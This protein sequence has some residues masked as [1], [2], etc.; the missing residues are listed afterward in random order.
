[1]KSAMVMTVLLVM[2]VLHGCTGLY[3]RLPGERDVADYAALI[4]RADAM[5]WKMQRVTVTP[6]GGR[7]LSIAV[8]DNE[9][10]SA[11]ETVVL[12]HG[13]TADNWSWRYM[14]GALTDYRIIA[15]D[16]PGCG[17][18]DAPQ[19]SDMGPEGYSPTGLARCS[20]EAL[21]VHLRTHPV[22]R[23]TLTAH[24]YG[25]A[26]VL[27]MFGDD[28]L[29]G[30]YQD[31]LGRVKLLALFAPV[32]M[33]IHEMPASVQ[34]A[35]DVQDWQVGLAHLLGMM[36]DLSADIIRNGMEYERCALR[37]IADQEAHMLTDAAQRHAL[38][39]MI[40]SVIP[41][42]NGKTIDWLAAEAWVRGYR[43]VQVPCMIVWGNHDDVLDRAGG[44]E[45]QHEIPQVKL[46]II[47]NARHSITLEQPVLCAQ[48]LRDFVEDR[49]GPEDV[50]SVT[51]RIPELV[52][53][54]GRQAPRP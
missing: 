43:Q 3:A 34:R 23:F 21:R 36:P 25:G 26:V 11:K 22:E 14:R 24:S 10:M 38:Q 5:P 40:A 31:V 2:C 51:A 42:K 54:A 16:L 48:L 27:R 17:H 30:E 1:M 39:W 4:S 18:S 52:T 20:L 50:K 7:P 53:E 46:R 9:Q 29:R 35:A 41:S 33:T 15:V 13:I 37:E 8:F 28:A 6:P 47:E 32:H 44:F 45:M 19:L 12:F 49:L